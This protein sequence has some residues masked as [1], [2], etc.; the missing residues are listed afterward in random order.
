MPYAAR[1]PSHRAFAA[2]AAVMLVGA[3]ARL[4]TWDDVF[5]PRGVRLLGDTDS[6]YHVLRAE[7]LLHG[8]P[9]DVWFDR[10]LAHP[11]GAI[12]PWPPGFDALIAGTARALHGPSA[13]RA[14][15][16]R[17]ALFV[18]VAVSLLALLVQAVFALRWFGLAGAVAAGLLVALLP[19]H[20]GF[21]VLGRPDQHV[22]EGLVFCLAVAATVA[23]ARG[24]RLAPA[25][26]ALAL[27]AGPWLWHGSALILAFTALLAAAAFVVRPEGDE[28][29]AALLRGVASGAVAGGAALGLSVLAWGPP[30]ELRSPGLNGLS[31]FHPAATVTA[32]AAAALLARLVRTRPGLRPAARVITVAG[33]G[34]AAAAAIFALFPGAVLHG[35][36]SLRATDPWLGTITEFQPAFFGQTG[37]FRG[38]LRSLLWG[39]G[40]VLLAPVA[41]VAAFR[42]RWRAAP[43]RRTAL[44][45]LAIGTIA[46]VALFVARSR[47]RL[48]AGPFL[49]WWGG[50]LL[51]DLI[52][53][54]RRERPAWYGALAGAAGLAMLAP[55][56]V[57]GTPSRQ[58]VEERLVALLS[59]LRD[60]PP[61]SGGGVLAPWDLGHAV[62][63]YAGRPAVVTPFGTDLGPRGMRD[64]AAFYYAPTP[65]A[66]EALLRDRQ[67]GFVLLTHDLTYVERAL[68]FAPEGS[69]PVISLSRD[70]FGAGPKLS[71]LPAFD[72]GLPG[73]LY[74]YDGVP[75]QVGRPGGFEAARLVYESSG[76]GPLKLFEVVAGARIEVSGA[77]PG[78]EVLAHV[79]V[80]TKEGRRFRWGTRARAGA[81]GRATLRVPY[82][83]GP[84]G[85]S[86]ASV[87]GVRAGVRAGSVAVPGAAVVS[88]AAVPVSL[89]DA[90][91]LP[92]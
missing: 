56:A 64:Q 75:L 15:V 66:A 46:F 20:V 77:A 74:D 41:G 76:P 52:D 22:A 90:A 11:E 32:G 28:R 58:P 38:D 85:T 65:E 40:P 44:L 14:D 4:S 78:V 21:G 49:T 55:A 33:V 13:S 91:A 89:A 16:E 25:L 30:A 37:S 6:H 36:R 39:T 26:L 8:E 86:A 50:L 2:L 88:G 68:P 29:A 80:H 35:W 24:G 53:R 48:Y 69:A 12:I 82:A 10:G 3:A 84:N 42:R 17:V 27:A 62:Q 31:L 9:A 60:Y 43:D 47:F 34:L 59:W 67:I 57:L 18:P 1:V 7:R 51:A 45:V 70:Y 54:A 81:D 23:C 61:R 92:R 83:T 5:T 73:W 79:D 87:Y 19:I 72:V 63:Y 71:T